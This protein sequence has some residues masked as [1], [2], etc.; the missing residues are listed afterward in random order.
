V[1][2]CFDDPDVVHVE[3]GADPL[4][5]IEIVNIELIMPIWRWSNGAL[6][7]AKKAGKGG[8]KK[9]LHEAEIFERLLGHLNGGKSARSFE[10]LPDGRSL[11]PRRSF[12]PTSPSFTR[13]TW[14]RRAFPPV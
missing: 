9:F 7:K 3:G 10:G 6:I 8:D 2:R 12:C 14:T 1:V 5:D 4:R 13:Q 11:T